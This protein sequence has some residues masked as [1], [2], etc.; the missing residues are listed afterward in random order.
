M[1]TGKTILMVD[2][3]GSLRTVVKLALQKVGYRVVEAVDAEEATLRLDTASPDLIVCD[4]DMS[5]LDGLDFTRHV[6]T[7]HG[8]RFTPV[9]MLTS[10]S[11]NDRKA[12]GRAA[13]VR[14]WVTKPFQPAHLVDVVARLC[15]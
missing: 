1:N 13:G 2:D 3:S 12:E 15:P 8:H 7:L 11:H 5:R 9:V 14:A 10:E 6:R 4:L